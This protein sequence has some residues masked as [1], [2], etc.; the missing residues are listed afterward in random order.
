MLVARVAASVSSIMHAPIVLSERCALL[1]RFTVNEE[2]SV[3]VAMVLSELIMNA[4]KHRDC[5]ASVDAVVLDAREQ[6]CEAQIRIS[7]PGLLPLDFDFD[8]GTKTGNGLGL[9]RSLLPRRGA[10]VALVQ[11]DDCVLASLTLRAPEV[12]GARSTDLEA[13]A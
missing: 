4:V 13:V 6:P 5:A 2:E 1:E 8:A 10:G 3:P 12:L 9:I 7:N 11:E